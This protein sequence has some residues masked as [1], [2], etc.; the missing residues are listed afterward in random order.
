[1]HPLFFQNLTNSVRKQT[2][3]QQV[4]KM[5]EVLSL[6]MKDLSSKGLIFKDVQKKQQEIPLETLICYSH[7]WE[8]Q[9]TLISIPTLILLMENEI[10]NLI[11]EKKEDWT[12]ETT[13]IPKKIKK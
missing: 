7:A 3:T 11:P 10:S 5:K 13:K 2:L 9:S 6:F 8:L 4:L 1:M 12:K